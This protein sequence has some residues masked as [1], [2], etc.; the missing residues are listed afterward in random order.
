MVQE[1]LIDLLSRF[2]NCQY[3]LTL[4]KGYDLSF[5]WGVK[6][7][8]LLLFCFDDSLQS[9]KKKGHCVGVGANLKVSLFV[10]PSPFILGMGSP[11]RHPCFSKVSPSILMAL[12][13][14]KN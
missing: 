3:F 13:G 1:A 2:T 10:T 6:S 11:M 5:V 12:A 4:L 14:L 9:Q 7:Y 8:I